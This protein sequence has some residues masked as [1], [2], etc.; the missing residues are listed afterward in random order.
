MKTK[1]TKGSSIKNN[2]INQES[3]KYDN[4]QSFLDDY[5]SKYDRITSN[6]NITRLSQ[7][8]LDN[9]YATDGILA[10]ICDKPAEDMIRQ[11]I[12]INDDNAEDIE[13]L[14]EKYNTLVLLEKAIRYNNVYGGSAIVFDVDDGQT[15][16]TPLDYSKIKNIKSF[17][18]VDRWYLNPINY[19][20]IKEPELY[21]LNNGAGGFMPIH[22]S[23]LGLFK[24]IDSGLRN[25][26]HNNSWGDSK[27]LRLISALNNYNG[28][29]DMLPEILL[30]YVTNIFK[31]KGMTEKIINGQG[32]VI[33][34]KAKYIQAVKNLIGA[35]V[36]DQ[37]DDY[38][39]RTLNL[40]GLDDLINRIEK[41]LCA[42]ANM[43]H[44]RLFEE[45]S[46]NTLSNNGNTSEQS[47]QYYDYIKFNQI[48]LLKPILN[49]IHLIFQGFKSMD[50]NKPIKY[51]FNPL[52]QKTELEN[53]QIKEIMSKTDTNYYNMGLSPKTILLNRFGQGNYSTETDLT[54]LNLDL[55]INDPKQQQNY[56][57]KV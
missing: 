15:T 10:K 27:I 6:K 1:K 47:K 20:G 22:C 14:H 54:G 3:R 11:G 4:W 34:T 39:T 19:N 50:L 29:H 13:N 37:E 35:M 17:F 26:K 36:V 49:Q 21:N 40:S 42:L 32:E 55:I 25:K 51:T 57:I 45:S 5:N 28:S 43:P 41:R 44:T 9:L 31:F 38:I 30:Q 18:V 12:D 16:D 48:K 46:G 52:S 33:K 23:R 2:D 8:E 53:V 7:G 24:G 56:P